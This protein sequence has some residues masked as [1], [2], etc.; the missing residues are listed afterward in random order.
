MRQTNSDA[1][2]QKLIDGQSLYTHMIPDDSIP[3]NRPLHAEGFYLSHII[4]VN[5]LYE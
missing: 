3:T 4:M 2:I 5:H 1:V